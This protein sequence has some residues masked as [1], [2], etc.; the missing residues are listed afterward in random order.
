M[1]RGIIEKKDKRELVNMSLIIYTNR[2]DIPSD[3][4]Y[5][6]SN[7]TFF[8]SVSLKNSATTEKILKDIDKAQYN[9]PITF[10]GRDM[11][12]GALNKNNLSTGCKTLLNIISNPDKCFNIIECGKNVF[13]LLPLITTGHILWQ[14]PVLHVIGTSECDIII[15]NKHFIDFKQFLS[16]V[17][18]NH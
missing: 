16:Y 14:Y 7:D 6:H 12:L 18:D 2:K 13:R 3:V 8:N 15:D 4:R 5:I 10:I 1:F 9:S 11:Q 17:M